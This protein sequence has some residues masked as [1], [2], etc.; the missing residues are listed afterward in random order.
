MRKSSFNFFFFDPFNREH[1]TFHFYGQKFGN[2]S[3]RKNFIYSRNWGAFQSFYQR[4][5]HDF[6]LEAV[7]LSQNDFFIKFVKFEP[8]ETIHF[9]NSFSSSSSFQLYQISSLKKF[10]SLFFLKSIKYF[11]AMTRFRGLFD[12]SQ[13]CREWEVQIS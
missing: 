2:S 1:R 4:K 8:S 11:A 10:F 5:L 12:V 6:S 13:N 7:C 3:A 9:V